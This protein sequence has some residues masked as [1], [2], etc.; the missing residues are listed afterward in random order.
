MRGHVKKVRGN[1]YVVLE[2]DAAPGERQQKWISPR[3]ELGLNRRATKK[4]TEALLVKKLS[5]LNTGTYYDRPMTHSA[6][7]LI[8][9]SKTTRSRTLSRK[10]LIF[11]S[12]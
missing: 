8:A 7:T 12:I 10:R 4:E 2:L 1:Y 11:T 3:K 9:G 5:E 6:P